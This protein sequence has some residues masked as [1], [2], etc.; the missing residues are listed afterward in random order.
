LKATSSRGKKQGQKRSGFDLKYALRVCTQAGK[1]KA[2]VQIYSAMNLYEEAVHRSLEVVPEGGLEMAKSNANKPDDEEVRRKLWL[3]IAKY[4]IQKTSTLDTEDQTPAKVGIDILEESQC[5]KIEDILPFFPDFVKIDA[6]KSE[7]CSSLETYNG[8]I[9]ELKQ[10]MEDYSKS[11]DTIRGQ[12]NELEN[13]S[14]ELPPGARCRI[15]GQYLFNSEFYLFPDGMAFSQ[16]AL[17]SYVTP[18]LPPGQQ[19]EVGKLLHE[20]QRL[21]S[22]LNSVEGDDR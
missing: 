13:R 12:I 11:A 1:W 5:L 17:V 19:E 21:K 9:E 8:K 10:E 3:L 7:I 6:F 22:M 4:V 2:C 16:A 18:H 14:I 15:S 20:I